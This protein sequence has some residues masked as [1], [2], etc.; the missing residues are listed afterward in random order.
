[1]TYTFVGTHRAMVFDELRND[2]YAQAIRRFVTPD[3]VVL[4]LGAGL[5]VH[6]LMA[7]KA[8]AR[9]VYLVEPESVVQIALEAARANGVA[10]RIV[11]L[12][13]DIEDVDLPEQVD[14][15][16]SVLAGNLLYSEDL[17]PSLFHA[18][19]RY[20][21]PE[22]RLVPDIAELLLAPVSA[23]DIHVKYV[24]RWSEPTLALDFSAA[25]RF[26]ANEI[27]WPDRKEL[28]AQAV[29]LAEGVVVSAL[30][31]MT[32]TRADCLGGARCRIAKS[33]LCHGILGWIRMRLGN[34]WLSSDPFGPE[35][36]WS[37]GLLPVDPPL[38]LEA[39]E[40]VQ[41][42]L[43]RPARG[44]W[45]WTVTGP[46]GTRR[47]SSFLSH[48]EAPHRLRRMAPDHRTTLNPRGESTLRILELMREGRSNQEIAATLA[49]AEPPSRSGVDETLQQV[50][51]LALRY[52]KRD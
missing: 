8:G 42:R 35:V 44:D 12:E 39:G 32:A 5:G 3:S 29:R 41:V 46:A 38:Q 6:G 52:G 28:R 19:D 31:L 16:I 14:L 47:H 33:G 48:P 15:I 13:G 9:R 45:T 18:R 17:L 23:P 40:E 1:M 34:E 27:L 49:A 43:Q 30:D 26:A 22:G 10:E 20:L 2:L 50:Q 4:D 7:A 51:A 11:V 25:R 24:G 36:H 21:K 37:P